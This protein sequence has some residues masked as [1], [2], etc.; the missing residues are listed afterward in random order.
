MIL[1]ALL[2]SVW[3]RCPAERE[4]QTLRRAQL[5]AR[6]SAE[7]CSPDLWRYYTTLRCT[8]SVHF[9]GPWIE[10]I[11]DCWWDPEFHQ[12]SQ[13]VQSLPGFLDLCWMCAVPSQV[14]RDVYTEVLEAAHPLHRCPTDQS[15]KVHDGMLFHWPLTFLTKT[16]FTAVDVFVTQYYTKL[17]CTSFCIM[18]GLM[19][20]Q[21]LI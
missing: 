10:S 18:D 6:L 15:T 14:L 8:E 19:L 13:M 12:L 20:L 5:S 4:E 21:K 3:Y 7:L 2:C 17:V 16:E 11:Q 1:T 9:Y